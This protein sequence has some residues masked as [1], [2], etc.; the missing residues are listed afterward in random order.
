MLISFVLR[1]ILVDDGHFSLRFSEYIL[2][3]LRPDLL[4][5]WVKLWHL[6][7]VGSLLLT[8]FG[9]TH[10]PVLIQD[11]HVERISDATVRHLLV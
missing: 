5:L 3:S 11:I 6:F 2:R 10:F 4:N 7:I 9:L 1:S 8:D